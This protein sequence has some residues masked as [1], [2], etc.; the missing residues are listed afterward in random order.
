MHPTCTGTRAA[1]AA[2]G[3]SSRERRV[4]A[5]ALSALISLT[6]TACGSTVAQTGGAAVT[7]G[8][9]LG[10]SQGGVPGQSGGSA[11][12]PAG[13]AFSG[14]VPGSSTERVSAAGSAGAA[15]ANGSPAAGS[16]SDSAA[17]TGAAGSESTDSGGARPTGPLKIGVLTVKPA[18]DAVG[19]IGGEQQNS[20]AFS[21]QNLSRAFVKALN[22]EGGVAGRK[23]EVVEYAQ[24]AQSGSYATDME[25]ACA[26][27]TQDN[28]VDVVLRTQ[29]GGI[30]S[31]NY[32][33]CLTKA[34]VTSLEMSFAVGDETYLKRH[35][36]LYN[37]AAPSVDRRMRGAFTGLNK[38]GYLTGKNKIGILVEDCSES[39]NAYKKTLAPLVKSLGLAVNTRSIGCLRGFSDVGAFSS[40]VQAAV[41]P[42]RS[43]GVDRVAFVSAWEVLMLLFFD[44]NAQSQGYA[45][46]YA[47]TSNSPVGATSGQFSD[48]QHRRMRGI[49]WSPNTDT[50]APALNASAKKCDA[51]LKKEGLTPQNQAEAALGRSVCDVFLYFKA[52]VEAAGGRSDGESLGAGIA[53]AATSYVSPSALGGRVQLG[54]GMQDGPTQVAEFDFVDSC[55][56]F[57]YIS[58]PRALP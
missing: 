44:T 31:E 3:G 47:L 2:G 29:L 42:F 52:S 30:M 34:G 9:G 15:G 41:L 38:S 5:A 8:D 17:G 57:R 21:E 18:G 37:V 36:R 51:M 10:A 11:F 26:K 28:K 55:R 13:A 22:A 14:T 54:Q 4:R 35:P 12:D 43:D 7:A 48:E 50:L 25:A 16:V 39:Q 40:Q 56:C 6:L 53:S 27:F 20:A 46:Q 49:G 23:I 1:K 45:P 19:A 24:D 32:N 58:A 33:A